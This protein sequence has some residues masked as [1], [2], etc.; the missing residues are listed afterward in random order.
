LP[1]LIARCVQPETTIDLAAVGA[2]ERE[3]L[4]EGLNRLRLISEGVAIAG[5]DTLDDLL[6]VLADMPRDRVPAFLESPGASGTFRRSCAPPADADRILPS[7]FRGEPAFDPDL[8]LPRVAE[9]VLVEESFVGAELE[10]VETDLACITGIR[11]SADPAH[12]VVAAVDAKAVEVEVGSDE[13]DLD[14]V[15]EVGQC[16]LVADQ[17]PPPDH[18]VDLAD[19]DMEQ[20]HLGAGRIGHGPGQ[21]TRSRRRR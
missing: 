16:T 21:R 9:F 17:K 1:P 4:A 7:R 19:P 2:L 12:T 18:G 14:S 15:M 11:G 10:A 5:I 13:G 8:V 3:P 20:A 6:K